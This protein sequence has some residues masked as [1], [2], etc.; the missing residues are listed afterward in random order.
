MVDH[1]VAFGV[2]S[3]EGEGDRHLYTNRTA[4]Y[5]AHNLVYFAKLL[6]ENPIPTNLK[7]FDEEAKK[8]SD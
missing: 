4:R 2:S 6:R 3:D 5:M 1:N 8:V 7:K